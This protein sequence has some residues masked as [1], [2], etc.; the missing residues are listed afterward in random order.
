VLASRILPLI[1]PLLRLKQAPQ[2]L[3]LIK[4]QPTIQL[5]VTPEYLQAATL[6]MEIVTVTH[7]TKP[8]IILTTAQ[9]TP[10]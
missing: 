2:S 3:G 7:S 4:I 1:L 10:P 8:E 5:P 9:H 6:T